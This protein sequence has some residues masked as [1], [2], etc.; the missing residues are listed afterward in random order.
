MWGGKFGLSET[1]A[2]YVLCGVEMADEGVGGTL[3]SRP[4]RKKAVEKGNLPAC[5]LILKTNRV[6]RIKQ[7]WIECPSRVGHAEPTGNILRFLERKNNALN[8]PTSFRQKRAAA[9]RKR[10]CRLGHFILGGALSF[11]RWGRF[12]RQ[13]KN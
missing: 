3:G 6:G 12:F 4:K 9:R 5:F 13:K 8:E 11:W 10:G 1:S 7:N 2:L